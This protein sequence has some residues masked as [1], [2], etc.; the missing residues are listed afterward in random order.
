MTDTYDTLNDWFHDVSLEKTEPTLVYYVGS[1]GVGKKTEVNRV[2]DNEDY[3]CININC[4]YDKV[5]S[6]FKKKNFVSELCHII[7]NKNIETEV[8]FL[9]IYCLYIITY[10]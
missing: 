5:H 8:I 6:R 3:R 10:I 4:I 2:I 9:R 1:T 7:T